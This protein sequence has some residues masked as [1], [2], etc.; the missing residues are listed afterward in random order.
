MK[1]KTLQ[2]AEKYKTEM[3]RH[4]VMMHKGDFVKEHQKLIKLLLEAGK[5][6][7]EQKK[8]LRKVVGGIRRR[9]GGSTS[10]RCGHHKKMTRLTGGKLIT[11]PEGFTDMGL[12]CTNWKTLETIGKVDIEATNDE[13]KKAFEKVGADIKHGWEEFANLVETDFI[14][15]GE[16]IKSDWKQFEGQWE[17]SFLTIQTKLEGLGQDIY[18]YVKEPRNMLFMATTALTLLSL[19]G[20]CFPCALGA[21]LLDKIGKVALDGWGS[22]TPFDALD[23]FLSVI[24]FSGGK[25]VGY[26]G[27]YDLMQSIER[28]TIG[29]HLDEVQ[30]ATL[31][32]SH[33]SSVAKIAV[34][35][36]NAMN[37]DG[38]DPNKVVVI[39]KNLVDTL[40]IDGLSNIMS[41]E[42]QKYYA[43]ADIPSSRGMYKKTYQSY[44]DLVKQ[45]L[46]TIYQGLNINTMVKVNEFL[47]KIKSKFSFEPMIIKYITV[48]ID[49]RQAK[50]L[51]YTDDDVTREI[52]KA[53]KIIDRLDIDG[54]SN[55][56]SKETSIS[57]NSSI[58]QITYDDY[59]TLAEE[60][61]MTIFKGLNL[62]TK[63]KI[64]EF[65]NDIKT[66]FA[67]D[68]TIV[69]YVTKQI[70]PRQAGGNMINDVA[71]IIKDKTEKIAQSPE[72]RKIVEEVGKTKAGQAVDKKIKELEKFFSP[73]YENYPN[74]SKKTLE[75]Y[76]NDII[77]GIELTRTTLGKPVKTALEALSLGTFDEARQKAGY[78][79][80]FH[81]QMICSVKSP[82]G[83]TK[84]IT[85]QKNERIIISD[86]ISGLDESTEFKIIPLHNK[87]V[88][89]NEMLEKTRLKDGDKVFFGYDGF[90]NRGLNCQSFIKHLLEGVGLWTDD[91]KKFTYQDLTKVIESIPDL[92]RDLINFVPA[93]GNWFSKVTGQGIVGGVNCEKLKDMTPEER[94]EVYWEI[95]QRMAKQHKHTVNEKFFI[96]V[97]KFFIE[98][99]DTIV[100]YNKFFLMSG[101]PNLIMI[102]IIANAYSYIAPPG[103]KYY[104]PC[105]SLKEKIKRISDEG[106]KA[107]IDLSV[108]QIKKQMPWTKDIFAL[109]GKGLDA[110]EDGYAIHDVLVKRSVPLEEAQKVA[111][112]ILKTKKN[113]YHRDTTEHY[114]FRNIPKTKFISRSF[115]TKVVNK[116]VEIIFGKLKE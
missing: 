27:G 29:A 60:R 81:L 112:D 75:K 104:T 7:K 47:D 43:L 91:I 42:A 86:T 6:G 66:K 68:P 48:K 53:K 2:E 69:N 101:N 77:T 21:T 85:I 95:Q 38:S 11:C 87:V 55:L 56:T 23:V 90:N 30:Q 34:A 65:L 52:D 106:F 20:L 88:S 96:P 54:L 33:L 114:R 36:Y 64:D 99:G 39:D 102:G 97:L 1:F 51:G 98:T 13:I 16:K 70:N 19:S 35:G 76:G 63:V 111:R 110:N 67:F 3:N 72:F 45:R 9:L 78:D 8:E 107:I 105:E 14:K 22:L 24:Q 73:D 80:Y 103:S 109:F 5:E 15:L 4:E 17:Q 44:V 93:L 50:E 32:V 28:A 26:P 71:K 41:K 58:G 116:D 113:K 12:T 31:I 84:K 57:P 46:M 10:C 59:I 94:K 100:K 92:G 82:K 83:H 74:K 79:Q 25:V 61:I 18:N 49:P 108:L 40:D 37:A 89:M 115:R 62:N